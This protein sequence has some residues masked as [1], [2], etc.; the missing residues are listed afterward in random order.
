MNPMRALQEEAPDLSALAGASGPDLTRYLLVCGLLVLLIA[1]L[2]YGMRRLSRSGFSLRPRT[3]ALEAL[4]VLPLGGR[5]RLAVV[6]CY[7]QSFLIGLGDKEM[8]LLATLPADATQSAE[9]PELSTLTPA[10]PRAAKPRRAGKQS[11]LA[12]L[13]AQAGAA[14]DET[15]RKD[16]P[17]RLPGGGMIG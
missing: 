12:V 1:A 5:H 9:A 8:Q 3:R 6:R 2:G 14:A 16:A 10:P 17:P 4:D 13:R 15:R 11:F 7:D